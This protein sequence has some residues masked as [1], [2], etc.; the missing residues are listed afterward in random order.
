MKIYI[1]MY[2]IGCCVSYIIITFCE[3]VSSKK[4]K[5]GMNTFSWIT[6]ILFSWAVVIY[7]IF[8]MTLRFLKNKN[9]RRH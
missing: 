8:Q 6:G 3:A 5:K 7:F 9:S 1:S 2:L 4:S